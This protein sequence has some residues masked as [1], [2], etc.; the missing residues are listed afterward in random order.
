QNLLYL[1]LTAF[2]V[3]F[4]LSS[5]LWQNLKE[6]CPTEVKQRVNCGYPGIPAHECNAKGCCFEARPPGV[7]WCMAPFAP[8]CDEDQVA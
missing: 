3:P 2:L 4:V 5:A 6:V 1:C 8:L 7:P